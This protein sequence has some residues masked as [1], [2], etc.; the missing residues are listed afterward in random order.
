MTKRIQKPKLTNSE[1][2]VI[3]NMRKKGMVWTTIAE[4]IERSE[5]T[6]RQAHKKFINEFNLPPK[7][8]K[9]RT[10]L[11]TFIGRQI[12]EAVRS[13]PRVSVP[14]IRTVLLTNPENNQFIPSKSTIRRYMIQK[15]FVSRRLRKGPLISSKNRIIRM[16][17]AKS[18]LSRVHF[19]FNIESTVSN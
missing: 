16:Q 1:L 4:I 3:D 8:K 5:S 2:T 12:I 14:A 18:L 17:Y 9:R 6:C 7:L 11:S 15:G 13:N 19:V 10:K